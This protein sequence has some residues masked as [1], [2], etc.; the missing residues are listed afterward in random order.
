MSMPAVSKAWTFVT[1]SPVPSALN[2]PLPEPTSLT[3]LTLASSSGSNMRSTGMRHQ[4]KEEKKTSIYA[5]SCS[6]DL[7]SIEMLKRAC[8]I[9]R[10]GT[11]TPNLTY[12][13]IH[14]QITSSPEVWRPGA[15]L[16]IKHPGITAM[17]GKCASCT[18]R[19]SGDWGPKARDCSCG[20]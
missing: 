16:V 5:T 9:S 12:L 17:A 18:D 11:R 6:S 20:M 8:L 1:V 15:S 10:Q 3:H 4:K 2:N 7:P 13:I 19:R 14:P